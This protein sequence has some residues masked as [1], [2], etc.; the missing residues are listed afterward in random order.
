MQPLTKNNVGHNDLLFH[1]PVISE[2][3]V[4]LLENES[5]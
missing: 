1:G 4:I 2:M 3:N 5:V